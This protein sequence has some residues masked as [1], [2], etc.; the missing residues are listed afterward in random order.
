MSKMNIGALSLNVATAGAP[1]APTLI[2]AHPLGASL[3]V[4]DEVAPILAKKFFVVRFDARGHGGSD[5]PPGPYSLS[6]LGGDVVA[7]MDALGL[8]RAHFVGLSMSG[9][10]GQWLMIHAP[11]RLDRVV[12]SN[13]AAW[14]PGPENWNARIRAARGGGMAD[15]AAA[16]VQRWLT[17]AFRAT[18]PERY[19]QIEKLV[20]ATPPLGYA[21]CCA[22]LRDAD[23]RD[24]IR[25][26]PPRPTLVIVG[27]A[28]ASTPPALGEALAGALPDARL[29]RLPAAHLS[30]VEAAHPFLAAVEKFLV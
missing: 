5:V 24:A 16:V 23:L 10:I 1:G 3:S 13:T 9:A 12:L 14:F 25:A 28:D 30:C 19:Q 18:D 4:W 2:L 26:A 8:A 29:V 27:D 6:D 22:A 21:A 15:L 7:L 20:R 11:D 17:P